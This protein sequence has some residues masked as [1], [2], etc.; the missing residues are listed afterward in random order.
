MTSSTASLRTVATRVE[1]PRDAA[2]YFPSIARQPFP[3]LLESQAGGRFTLLGSNPYRVLVGKGD[4][5]VDWREGRARESR[6]DPWNV[7]RE[8]L[9]ERRVDINDAAVPFVGGAVGWLGYDLAGHLERLPSNAV[10]DRGFPD[11]MLAFYD[12][13]VVVDR[14]TQAATIVELSERAPKRAMTP[15]QYD[16]HFGAVP[17]LSPWP[18]DR[19]VVSNFSREGY[20]AAVRAAKEHIAAG[21]IYQVNLSQRF[22]TRTG[23]SP[24]EIY[25]RLRDASPSPFGALLLAGR[26]AVVS[27]SPELFLRREGRTVST[28]PI[29]GTRRRDADSETDARLRD[30]LLSSPKDDAEL[31]MIVDL[32]RNDLGRVCEYGS[33]RVS[34][35]KALET[36]PTV[37]HL[38]ATVEGRLRRDVDVVDLLKATFPTG[39]VTGAPKI[40]AMQILD[41][42]EPTRRAAYTGA[43][44][45]LGLD[46][47][48]NLSVGIRLIEL[49]GADAWFQVGGGIVADSDPDAEFEETLAKAAGMVRALGVD[50][51]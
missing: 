22:H 2:D 42:L 13:A 25:R 3:F 40:R 26:R 24:A 45:F 11:L 49:H 7:L 29:K 39:S 16:E 41:E 15:K 5:V 27:S 8:A 50:V 12:R 31:A 47:A 18:H 43:L 35:P 37:H 1:L 48:V 4:R 28:R 44:G 23:L 10:D 9:T 36:H 38:V 19:P 14:E 46:G 21:D 17:P 51:G 33:V 6:G 34:V 20:L 30:E 32:E